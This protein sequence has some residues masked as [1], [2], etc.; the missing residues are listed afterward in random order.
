MSS[1]YVVAVVLDTE[2]GEQLLALASRMPVWIV[3]TPT[4]CAAAQ[5][6]WD[7]NARQTHLGGVTTFKID[8]AQSPETWLLDILANVDLHHGQYSQNPPYR[9]VEV[10][11]AK[12]T[13]EL[14][15]AFAQFG[16]VEFAQR[17]GGFVATKSSIAV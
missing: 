9:A 17:S 16:L 10:F 14:R 6:C 15:D 11:G 8:Q 3:D 12:L 7:L 4:N 2:F 5:R 1:S 13:S